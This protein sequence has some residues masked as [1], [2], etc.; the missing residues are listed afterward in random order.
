MCVQEH[1]HQQRRRATQ[2]APG[3]G[4]HRHEGAGIGGAFGAG[5]ARPY[6]GQSV[7]PNFYTARPHWAEHECWLCCS[8]EMCGRRCALVRVPVQSTSFISPRHTTSNLCRYRTASR[9]VSG[10]LASSVASAPA[11]GC[12][13]GSRYRSLPWGPPLRHSPVE[14]R[15]R[16]QE[17]T[18]YGLDCTPGFCSFNP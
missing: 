5:A 17:M 1:R 15:K 16:S 7:D 14:L 8:P 9:R 3:D 12:I 2:G 4:T 13:Q 11:C 6:V 10:A 18:G